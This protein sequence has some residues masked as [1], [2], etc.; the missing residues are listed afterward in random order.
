LLFV[1]ANKNQAT[2]KIT[3][4]GDAGA[5]AGR[6]SARV[7]DVV[8]C[9]PVVGLGRR[10]RVRVPG[11]E[12]EVAKRTEIFGRNIHL[13][14][15]LAL[16]PVLECTSLL[17]NGN[18]GGGCSQAYLGKGALVESPARLVRPLVVPNLS[19]LNSI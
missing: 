12:G 8:A 15:A 13:A 18:I 10:D 7:K 3:Q 17:I 19:N 9:H 11:F 2:A 5:L 14:L 6:H 16:R 1:T 4:M